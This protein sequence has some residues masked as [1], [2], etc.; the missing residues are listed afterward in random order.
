M[1][2]QELLPC[3]P[4]LQFVTHVN[5]SCQ[6]C[7]PLDMVIGALGWVISTQLQSI[8]LP[9]QPPGPRR[10]LASL[11]HQTCRWGLFPAQRSL[12]SL[13]STQPAPAGLLTLD[14][15]RGELIPSLYFLPY[16]SQVKFSQDLSHSSSTV[17]SGQWSALSWLGEIETGG[18]GVTPNPTTS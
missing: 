15:F 12:F 3:A 5:S 17:V 10:N 9:L 18:P 6:G 1:T 4:F 14:I 11:P 2:P 16:G 8:H 13:L 7:P